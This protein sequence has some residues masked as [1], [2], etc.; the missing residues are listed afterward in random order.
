[1]GGQEPQGLLLIVRRHPGT[2]AELHAYPV[3]RGPLRAA[4]DVVPAGAGDGKPGRELHQDDAELGGLAQRLEGGQEPVPGLVGY[5]GVD[6][7]EVHPVLAGLGRRLTQV[8]GQ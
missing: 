1:M 5:R 7:L 8:G 3:G 4:E 2:V 6:V